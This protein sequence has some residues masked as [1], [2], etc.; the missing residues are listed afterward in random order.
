MQLQNSQVRHPKPPRPP[1]PIYEYV[2][3]TRPATRSS[4]AAKEQDIDVEM[5]ASE[6]EVQYLDIDTPEVSKTEKWDLDAKLYMN[7]GH[8]RNDLEMKDN[9]AYRPT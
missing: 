7:E 6:S 4:K 1:P 9:I 2:P 3:S 5:K 8:N